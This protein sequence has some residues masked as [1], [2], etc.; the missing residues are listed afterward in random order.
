MNNT[1]SKI[2]PI[3]GI[4]LS[5]Y[6]IIFSL[7]LAKNYHTWWFLVGTYIIFFIFGM[8]KACLKIIP[9]ML[10][11]VLIF[12]GLTYIIKHDFMQTYSMTIRLCALSIAIIPGLCIKPNDFI[13]NLNTIRVPRFITLGMMI[14]ISF[15][16]MLKGEIKNIKEAMK[17]RGAYNIF[18]PKILYRAFIFPFIMRSINISDTLALSVETRG[19]DIKSKKYSVYKKVKIRFLDVLILLMIISLSMVVIFL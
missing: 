11:F 16:P 6:I 15:I 9:F 17:C 12:S 13:S 1:K 5:I 8:Y 7:I 2:Y 19:F 14:T 3:L 10:F 4:F 18:N